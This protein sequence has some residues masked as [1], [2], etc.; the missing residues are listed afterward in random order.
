MA[1]RH[2]IEFKLNNYFGIN[3]FHHYC[4]V[5][6][7]LTGSV[8]DPVMEACFAVAHSYNSS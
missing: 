6:R 8:F 1:R 5:K 3:L 4:D 2:L 7:H